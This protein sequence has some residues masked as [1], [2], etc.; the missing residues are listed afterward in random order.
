MPEVAPAV[1]GLTLAIALA[2]ALWGYRRGAA[3]AAA[4]LRWL[5]PVAALVGTTSAAVA[6]RWFE[7]W[8]VVT[9][10]MT[11]ALVAVVARRL[12][13]RR[14]AGRNPRPRRTR[15]APTPSAAGAVA[16]QIAGQMAGLLAGLV[17]GLGLATLL[18]ASAL[19]ATGVRAAL[20][21][22]DA[23]RRRVLDDPWSE[24]F[25][26]A[27]RGLVTHLPYVG[28]LGDEADAL[29][30]ILAA[31]PAAQR[32]L[33]AH[34]GWHALVELPQMRAVLNDPAIQADIAQLRQ[35]SIT[36]LYRLQ[37]HPRILA[38]F[39]AP[40]LEAHI[41]GLRPTA[42]IRELRAVASDLP[43]GRPSAP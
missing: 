39:A 29:L 14:R 12:V 24:L 9:P 16:G 32:R 13:G 34:R 1:G 23:E 36:P 4:V 8:G 22:G 27:H 11:G 40:D 21:R 2:G 17:A 20:A 33:A 3:A 35:G 5:V 10:L 7:P 25:R 41:E 43:A 19:T 15:S 28:P 26:V 31:E 30:S 18:W 38:L 37:R 6:A 42:L